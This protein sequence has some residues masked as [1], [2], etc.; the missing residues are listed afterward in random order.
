MG[1]ARCR[2]WLI[3]VAIFGI[4][5]KNRSGKLELLLRVVAGA[6]FHIF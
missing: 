1:L 3:F 4:E 2:I 5:A 6:G